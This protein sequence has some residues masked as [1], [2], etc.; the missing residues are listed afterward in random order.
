MYEDGAPYL[1]LETVEGVFDT[2]RARIP[3]LVTAVRE[4]DADRSR[5]F[6][7]SYDDETQL[8]LSRA[9]LEFLGYDFDRGRLDTAPHP[10]MSGTQFDA[11]VTTR[12][13]ESDP[14]DGLTATIHEFGHASYQLGLR[15]DAYGT[16][17]GHPRSSGVHES[18]SRFWENH[19]GRT[20]PFWAAVGDVVNDHLG[21]D[22]GVDEAHAAVNRVYPDNVIRVEADE[23]TY[24]MHIV[25]R[26]EIDRAFVE[27]E[28]EVDEIPALWDEKMDDYLGVV[29][30][31][32]AEGC[33]QDIH[34]SYGF[35]NFQSYTVG[36][37]LAAQLDAAI[38][39][40]LDVDEL[41][42]AGEFAPIREWMGE[43]VHRHG[44][45]YETP[46]LIERATGSALS[47]DRFVDY[48]G[49]KFGD[50]YGL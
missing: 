11:R 27:G 30:E 37:V 16:P 34:W 39:D 46:E 48:V 40:E 10:F 13:R 32:D 41:V 35:A 33:L 29:P 19:V 43:T 12:F 7:G 28:I 44:C 42:R 23:L 26:T 15:Q 50:I 18:Q 45:R 17:L 25:L 3:E 14:L 2:L 4:A 8:A 47:A 1:P 5:P 24:H 20:R 6:A 21:T 38:R 49:S 31:T 9:V 22:V 36:S